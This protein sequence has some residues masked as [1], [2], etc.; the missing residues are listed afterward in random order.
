MLT[1]VQFINAMNFFDKYAE[2]RD[3]ITKALNPYFDGNG[4]Y[5]KAADIL[6]EKYLM[7]L[8]QAMDI[9]EED[10]PI[11]YYLY[12]SSNNIYGEPDSNGVCKKIGEADYKFCRIRVGEK[13]FII[14]NA[15]DLYDYIKY[16]KSE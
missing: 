16:I 13:E 9:D 14:K 1:K 10:D 11:S 8:K 15:E 5:F 7:L 4:F 3:G 12:E 6:H 2:I